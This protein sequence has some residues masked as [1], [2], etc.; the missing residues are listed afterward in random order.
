MRKARYAHEVLIGMT[1]S[2][3]D[4]VRISG[5]KARSVQLWANAEAILANP[6]TEKRG[7]GI[8]RRYSRNELIIACCLAGFSR[9]QV[10]IGELK[11]IG[12]A[13]RELLKKPTV[14]DELSEIIDSDHDWDM[15]LGVI[16][17]EHDDPKAFIFDEYNIGA[18]IVSR[19]RG[20]GFCVVLPLTAHLVGLREV[21]GG[22]RSAEERPLR[23]IGQSEQ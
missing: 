18:R 22:G 2:L 3:A 15:F 10:G 6:A 16:W 19:L 5:A 20:L 9:R 13:V 1:Y 17:S 4:V 14:H 23:A 12:S 7:T 8:H 11:R 21:D